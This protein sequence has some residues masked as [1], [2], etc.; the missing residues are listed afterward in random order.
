MSFPFIVLT[1]GDDQHASY[2]SLSQNVIFR[3]FFVASVAQMMVLVDQYIVQIN[4]LRRFGGT[5]CFC[6]QAD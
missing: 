2:T 1:T 4:T 3:V 6:L 5:R